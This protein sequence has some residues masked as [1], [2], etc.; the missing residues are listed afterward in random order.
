MRP[1]SVSERR[2]L[3]RRADEN[4]NHELRDNDEQVRSHVQD[5]I[6]PATAESAEK[7]D[8]NAYRCRNDA[9]DQ[10][11]I[12]GTAKPGNQKRHV[13]APQ[14]VGSEEMFRARRSVRTR[15]NVARIDIDVVKERSKNRDK[16]RQEEDSDTDNEHRRL[17]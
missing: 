10:A 8:E 16:E 3:D 12:Q 2:F 5:F 13:V 15:H 17:H 14:M 11:H 9:S 1:M 4:E 7:P 6:N